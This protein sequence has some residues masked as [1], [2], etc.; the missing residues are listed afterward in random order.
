MILRA[1]LFGTLGS[2]YFIT[3][4]VVFLTERLRDFRIGLLAAYVDL[5]KAFDSVN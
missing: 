4:I 1:K 2:E 3:I 5:H